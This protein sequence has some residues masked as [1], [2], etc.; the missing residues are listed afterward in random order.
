MS[1]LGD[2]ERFFVAAGGLRGLEQPFTQQFNGRDAPLAIEHVVPGRI[3][4]IGRSEMG[5]LETLDAQE[6]LET[7]TPFIN[8]GFPALVVTA[9][10]TRPLSWC[11]LQAG[12]SLICTPL[13]STVAVDDQSLLEELVEPVVSYPYCS[14]RWSIAKAKRNRQE[15]S[16]SS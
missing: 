16:D 8:I 10:E 5:Y 14:W 2:G 15:K 6:R 3:Q 13:E 7:L 1:V 11:S 12:V 4:L 9:D